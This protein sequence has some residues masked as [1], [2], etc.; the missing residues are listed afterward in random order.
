MGCGGNGQHINP[1]NY[2][3]KVLPV[4]TYTESATESQMRNTSQAQ[5]NPGRPPG[6]RVFELSFVKETGIIKEVFR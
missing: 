4:I 2:K 1:H 6:G 5:A 3:A